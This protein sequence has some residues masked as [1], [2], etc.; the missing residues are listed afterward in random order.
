VSSPSTALP[1][2]RDHV[3][4]RPPQGRVTLGLRDVWAYRELLYFFAWRDLKIRYKQSI[5]G[6]GW[7][8]LQPI[9]MMVVF[10]VFFGR[11]ADIPSDGIPR[12]IF[13]YA[14]LLPW[15][16]FQQAA[17]LSTNSL[18]SNSALVTKVYFP[19]LLLPLSSVLSAL[20]DFGI[21]FVVLIALAAYYLVTGSSGVQL[22]PELLLIATLVPLIVAT[23]VTTGLWLSALN[24]RYR[25]VRYAVTFL[26][27]FWMFASP[28]AYPLSIIPERFRL[29]YSLNPMAGVIEGFRWAL[30][31]RGQP[32]G[33]PLLLSAVVV[34]VFFAGGLRYFRRYEGAVADVI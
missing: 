9:A 14:A 25:D 21:A 24:A 4:I 2:Q 3:A 16:Y 10:T 23:A 26:L 22:G 27:Q 8:V 1:R 29:V 19:R 33:L 20:V 15:T 7:A 11:L 32:P 18:I 31:G 17:T 13:Y 12:P 30:T 6:I 34:A 28:V 5:V